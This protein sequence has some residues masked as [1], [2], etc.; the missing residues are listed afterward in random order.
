MSLSRDFRRHCPF[1]TP[2]H[3]RRDIL[4]ALQSSA[5]KARLLV[6][7]ATG[8]VEIDFT[9]AQIL[10][11]L[12]RQCHADGVDFA[13]ARLELIRAQDAMARLASVNCS[14]RII[15]SIASKRLS[16]R[17]A[18]KAI[19]RNSATG[20]QG[21]GRHLAIRQPN[22]T[23]A[24]PTAAAMIHVDYPTAERKQHSDVIA[25]ERTGDTN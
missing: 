15:C 12:I 5:Q 16:R 14:V 13:I 1:S 17:L 10:R 9:A 6:L 4:D 8:I 22:S 7:E 11:D 24:A 21:A 18:N 23:T 2:I 20:L 3:F 25:D 19:G